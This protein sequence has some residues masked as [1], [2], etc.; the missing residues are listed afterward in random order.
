L[1]QKEEFLNEYSLIKNNGDIVSKSFIKASALAKAKRAMNKI[2]AMSK[3]TN[4][5][6]SSHPEK[7]LEQS[8]RSTKLLNEDNLSQ[9]LSFSDQ[10]NSVC[11][12][13]IKK[14]NLV[15]SIHDYACEKKG[16]TKLFGIK[17]ENEG[18][19]INVQDNIAH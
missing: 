13:R 16:A 9:V 7:T 14:Y 2:S 4:H 6:A 17:P 5:F 18:R 12:K 1:A 3:L 15:N 8:K 19:I 11:Y 10:L